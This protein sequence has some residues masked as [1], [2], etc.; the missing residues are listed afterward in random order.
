M[1]PLCQ[2]AEFPVQKLTV[3]GRVIAGA[4]PGV[5]GAES[6]GRSAAPPS[7]VL[8]Y[9]LLNPVGVELWPRAPIAILSK[10][11][12]TPPKPETNHLLFPC[13]NP[14]RELLP[15]FTGRA[16]LLRPLETTRHSDRANPP[17]PR[18][19]PRIRALAPRRLR[20]AAAYD[21]ATMVA[22]VV[23]EQRDGEGSRSPGRMEGE[24]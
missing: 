7:T 10:D 20:A 9:A 15:L 22:S 16:G 5:T 19:N 1:Q 18:P 17:F 12:E 23:Q 11:L 2:L 21:T 6:E 3:F 14:G 8:V 24:F 13:R 4:R